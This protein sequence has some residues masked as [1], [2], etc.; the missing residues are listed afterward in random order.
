ML[1]KGTELT[2]FKQE[3]KLAK[4]VYQGFCVYHLKKTM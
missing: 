1:Y 2:A 3:T 4:A